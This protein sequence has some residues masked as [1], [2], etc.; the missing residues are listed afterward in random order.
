MFCCCKS[1]NTVYL[2]LMSQVTTA[3]L[4]QVVSD[5][6]SQPYLTFDRSPSKFVQRTGTT[7]CSGKYS[8]KCQEDFFFEVS[9][10][11][12]NTRL[13]D[14]QMK[15]QLLVYFGEQQQN[16]FREENS[17]VCFHLPPPVKVTPVCSVSIL[18]CRMYLTRK[19]F[20]S[21]CSCY[22]CRHSPDI[23]FLYSNNYYWVLKEWQY[24]LSNRTCLSISI[25]DLDL[26]TYAH[27]AY[28]TC[29]LGLS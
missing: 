28:C 7:F 2:F 27:V 9:M 20:P 11:S 26:Y 5:L 10:V 17:T 1:E 8:V 29:T 13:P 15:E 3:V 16:S 18:C 19:K 23:I 6:S 4:M 21:G 12:K 25:E 22:L 24:F 14:I